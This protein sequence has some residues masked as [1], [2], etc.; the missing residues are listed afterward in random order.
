MLV[1]RSS[2]TLAKA[3]QGKVKTQTEAKFLSH[4]L[5]TR[6]KTTDM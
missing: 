3:M 2:G 1:L 6:E 4:K 5:N